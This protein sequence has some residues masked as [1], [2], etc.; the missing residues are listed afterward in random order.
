MREEDVNAWKEINL[1]AESSR[2]MVFLVYLR[3]FHSFIVGKVRDFS[4]HQEVDHLFSLMSLKVFGNL[5]TLAFTIK[6]NKGK[7]RNIMVA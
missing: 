1:I 5:W 2:M 6:T 7:R 3:L 4:I